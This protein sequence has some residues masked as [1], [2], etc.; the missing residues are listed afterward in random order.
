MH[1]LGVV[2]DVTERRALETQLRQAQKLEAIGQLAGG[3]AHD[4]NNLLTAILGYASLAS[5]GLDPQHPLRGHMEEIAMAGERGAGLTRQLLAFSRQQMLEP[6]LINLNTLVG[7]ISQMLRRLI[8]EHIELVARLTT[9]LDVILA[10]RTQIE[11]VIVNL[12]VNARDAMPAGG[13]LTIETANM[14]LDDTYELDPLVIRP[15]RYVMLAVSD[16]GTGID[17][18]TRRRMFDPFFT[19]K[20][21]GKGPG[22]GL[23]TVYGI[24]KQSGGYIWVYSEP[25]HGAAF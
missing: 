14:E 19:T 4:F 18:D 6:T 1:M 25:G 9:D 23:A 3:V 21:R 11:Q 12:A 24:I 22:L 2:I 13:R 5:D 10:D 16:T 20:E 8:G 15:G 17:E 7:D